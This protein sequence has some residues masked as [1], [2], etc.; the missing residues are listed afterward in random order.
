MTTLG[1]VRARARAHALTKRPP[2]EN[3]NNNN[4]MKLKG[5]M[6]LFR[7]IF[8]SVSVSLTVFSWKRIRTFLG[9]YWLMQLQSTYT[10]ADVWLMHCRCNGN[11][12]RCGYCYF[13]F[14]CFANADFG[15]LMMEKRQS[16]HRKE[17]K[18]SRWHTQ[19][20]NRW[21]HAYIRNEMRGT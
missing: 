7:L 16:E 2:L 18:A 6:N 4:D 13:L 9:H 12:G 19:V 21:T 5:R 17:P 15:M 14:L 20:K 3:N 11:Y 8:L 10:Y 1:E